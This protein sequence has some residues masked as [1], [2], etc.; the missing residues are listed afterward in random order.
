MKKMT[1]LA[2]VAAMLLATACGA[3][4]GSETDAVA[5][6]TTAETAAVETS[7]ADTLRKEDYGGAT[8]RILGEKMRDYY[9]FE[10]LTGD[11]INDAVYQRNGAVNDLYNILLEFDIVDW[12]SGDDVILQMTAAG[13]RN[14]DLLTCTHLYLG[15]SITSGCFR[16]WNDTDRVTLD[17]PWYVKAANDTYS[18]GDNTMLLFGD[19]LESTIRCTWCMVFNINKA[20]DHNLPDLYAAVDEGRWTIDYLMEVTND[21]YVDTDGNGSR[22]LTDFYGFV[23]DSYAAIDSFGRTC[24]LSAISKDDKNYPM[25]DFYKESTVDAYELLY[26]LY[27]ESTGTYVNN[28]AFSHLVDSFVQGNAVISNTLLQT[29]E[30]EEVRSMEDDFGVL[31]YPKMTEDQELGY[32]H[33]DGTF[34]AQMLSVTLGEDEIDKVATV[35]EALNALGYE[36]VRPALYE[37][38]LKT[39]LT[40]DEDSVRMLDLVLAGRRFSFDSLDESNFKLSPVQAMRNLLAAKNKDIASY[41]AKNEESCQ[42]WIAKIVEAYESSQQ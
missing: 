8:F 10:E 14:Y 25:L 6:T 30:D 32:S 42:A 2:L 35:A 17:S 34:S 5:D 3:G 7:V 41:Y 33:L 27:Y 18:I 23:T 20:T 15:S 9:T 28:A 38:A 22:D 21:L 24:G 1:V 31:P 26:K 11:V 19:F 4:T 16:S 40:R 13:D 36:M 37:V 29:L 12:Q 39:K